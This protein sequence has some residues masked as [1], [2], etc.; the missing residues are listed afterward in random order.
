MQKGI[1]KSLF[2]FEADFPFP[3]RA[4]AERNTFGLYSIRLMQFC[5]LLRYYRYPVLPRRRGAGFYFIYGVNFPQ[6]D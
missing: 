5:T 1:A 6:G 2:P 3:T 4:P